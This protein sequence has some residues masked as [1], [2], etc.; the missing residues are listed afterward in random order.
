MT[1]FVGPLFLV[2]MPRS[3]TKLLRTIINN[4]S[5]ISI[6]EVETEFL[7]Y[8][9]LHWDRFGDLSKWR[10]FLLFY[11]RV[12]N[13]PYMVLHHSEVGPPIEARTWYE[14]CRDFSAA[15]VFEALVR[16]DA[17][18]PFGADVIW[19]DKSPSYVRSLPLMKQLYPQARVVHI[20][21]DV[22]D[23]CLSLNKAL[24]KDMSR[25][26]Q[27][28]AD[29]IKSAQR[30]GQRLGHDYLEVRYEDLI[31]DPSSVAGRICAFVGRDFQPT[32]TTLAKP[33]E[34][35]FEALGGAGSGLRIILG[36]NTNKWRSELDRRTLMRIE[37]I[38]F[39][40]LRQCNYPIT[41]ATGQRRLS[42]P[43]LAARQVLDGLHLFRSYRRFD[44]L[45]TLRFFWNAF[46]I[47]SPSL[48][49][50]QRKLPP[51]FADTN[52]GNQL[53]Q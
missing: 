12:Q 22:R 9:A 25:A 3:G 7:P 47:A 10:N 52:S 42:A 44:R 8:W 35:P 29:D 40:T 16:H 18:V 53:T 24:A 30:T 26:A 48:K 1:M 50:W 5:A 46:L 38:A 43:S 28:W 51:E 11:G 13:S 19:G 36:D 14:S 32:M 33:A 4:H 37:T 23:Y 31:A 27:R 39:E 34:Q 21:R 49:P 15:G 17:G 2:G 20:T 45:T 6:L 41:I